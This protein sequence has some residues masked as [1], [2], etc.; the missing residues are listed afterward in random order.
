MLLPRELRVRV[1]E[2]LLATT[3]RADHYGPIKIAL[4][5]PV[6]KS[7]YEATTQSVV[8]ETLIIPRH[9]PNVGLPNKVFE[10]TLGDYRNDHW[11][12]LHRY[13]LLPTSPEILQT[14]TAVRDEASD[15]LYKKVSWVF[16][17]INPGNALQ[18]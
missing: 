7:T 11:V 1:Y 5:S 17:I 2:E 6:S 15:M 10:Y 8:L 16:A 4:S 3:Y 9:P 13:K 14:S 12:N 18:Y